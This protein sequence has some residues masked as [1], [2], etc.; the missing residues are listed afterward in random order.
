MNDTGSG[1]LGPALCK[2]ETMIFET[3]AHY[4]DKKYDEDREEIIN[5]LRE[6]GIGTVVNVEIGRASCRE[7]VCQYV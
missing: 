3:H 4:E 7:R 5:S 2:G 6:D 1:K